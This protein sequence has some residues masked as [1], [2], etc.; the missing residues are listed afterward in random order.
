M[1]VGMKL[2]NIHRVL[3]FKQ[4]DWLNKYIDFNTG[5]RK[6]VVNSFENGFLN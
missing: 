3:K 6:N 1:Y 2:V 5:K 4:C